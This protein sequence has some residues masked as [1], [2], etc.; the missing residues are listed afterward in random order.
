[1]VVAGRPAS[2]G[3]RVDQGYAWCELQEPWALEKGN[4]ERGYQFRERADL[5]PQANGVADEK[6]GDGERLDHG[7]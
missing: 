1:M 7:R 3:D 4:V 6:R 5:R 2:A